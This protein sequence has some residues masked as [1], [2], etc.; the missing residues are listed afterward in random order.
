[1]TLRAFERSLILAAFLC[2]NTVGMAADWPQ[3]GIDTIAAKCRQ[4]PRTDVPSQY[5]VAY[6]ACQTTAISAAIPWE[7]FASADM[8]VRT[9][10]LANVSA[11]AEGTMIAAAMVGARCFDQTVPH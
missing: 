10:D 5:Q 9:K 11:K 7:D 4:R 2:A 8:E 1:M 3:S 6:C